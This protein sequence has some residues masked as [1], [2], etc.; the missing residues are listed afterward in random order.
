[1]LGCTATVWPPDG[2]FDLTSVG[3]VPSGLVLA[4]TA[5]AGTPASWRVERESGD[6]FLRVET[7]NSG[8]TYNLCIA[9][10]E[11]RGDVDL[12]V[13]LR[14]DTGE[15]D[16][17]GGLIWGVQDADN[18]Y[19]T[20]WNPLEDNTR[21]YK[22]EDG[23]RH[24]FQSADTQLDPSDW[25]TLRVVREGARM[26]VFLDGEQILDHTD[27]TFGAGRVGL[28]TKADASVSFDDFEAR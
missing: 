22:V 26:T 10:G 13:R 9:E 6:G 1:L 8:H 24:Q 17:G 18:Y 5:G 3:G 19:V 23:T 20:R 12:S 15:E 25:H 16:Q 4:E 7:S 27:E 21:I 2:S 28:W 11:P 14:A